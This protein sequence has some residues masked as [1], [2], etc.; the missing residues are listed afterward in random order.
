[1]NCFL[2]TLPKEPQQTFILID[3]SYF[4]F[5]RYYALTTWWK[6]AY[7]DKRAEL[8]DPTTNNVFV[9]KFRK[10]LREKVLEIPKRLKLRSDIRPIMIV[11]RD[12]SREN[13]WRNDIYPEYKK[14]RTTDDSFMGGYFFRM[15]YEDS[16]FQ[17]AG[18]H[19]V[20]HHPRLEADDCIAIT[21]KKLRTM[22]SQSDVYI[23]A[24]DKDYV[25]LV[26]PRIHV[27]NL[28]F[29]KLTEQKVYTG[30][31]RRDLF[32]KIVSGDAS[33]NIPS[34]FPKCGIKTASKYYNNPELFHSALQKNEEFQ[35]RFAR[36]KTIVDF[37]CIPTHLVDEFLEDFED[38]IIQLT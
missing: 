9:E 37:E 26:E 15:V 31:P 7:P 22:Y 19:C 12:C 38:N 6:N 36:N 13:I 24:S 4:I 21:A 10:T 29:K 25:Q 14:H 17:D 2:N 28:S 16:L 32:C 11:G 3:G 20:L 35:N 1:M 18:V 34:V 23:I 33:D 27:L 8:D 5:Y 30:C